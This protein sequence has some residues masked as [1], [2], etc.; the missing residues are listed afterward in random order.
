MQHS[1]QLLAERIHI[2][3]MHELVESQCARG[4]AAH[5]VVLAG[6]Q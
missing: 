3:G 4:T 6:A 1:T 5:T 2:V